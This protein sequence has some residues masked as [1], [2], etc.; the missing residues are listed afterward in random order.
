MKLPIIARVMTVGILAS[1]AVFFLKRWE[2]YIYDLKDVDPYYNFYMG[3]LISIIVG[4]VLQVTWRLIRNG[5]TQA[6][7]W[8]TLKSFGK[9]KKANFKKI[10]VKK[11]LE[12]K[13][14]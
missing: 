9:E 2:I 5:F 7:Y 12:K 8:F 1:Q 13:K 11:L 10:P 4:F 14:A 3:I 6:Y